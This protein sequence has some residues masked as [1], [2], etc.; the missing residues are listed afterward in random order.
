MQQLLLSPPNPQLP[1]TT[2]SG[3]KEQMILLFFSLGSIALSVHYHP[4]ASVKTISCSLCKHLSECWMR[5]PPAPCQV[6]DLRCCSNINISSL[7]APYLVN[8]FRSI[9]RLFC[10]ISF[11]LLLWEPKRTPHPSVL[12]FNHH[13]ASGGLP[14]RKGSPLPGL[15]PNPSAACPSARHAAHSP[16]LPTTCRSTPC[17]SSPLSCGNIRHHCQPVPACVAKITLSR[18][19]GVHVTSVAISVFNVWSCDDRQAPFRR[20]SLLYK[21]PW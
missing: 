12:F 20:W 2:F 14:S 7:M 3:Y 15:P 19:L 16:V 9:T 8:Y 5:S 6:D 17:H 21:I 4:P 11:W 13:S 1:H 18:T 10:N